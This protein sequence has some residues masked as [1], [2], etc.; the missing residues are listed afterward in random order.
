M[1][2]HG[3]WASLLGLTCIAVPLGASARDRDPARDAT[4]YLRDAYGAARDERDCRRVADD[5][6]RVL[7][8]L[9]DRPSRRDL[10]RAADDLERTRDDAQRDCPRSVARDIDDA[11][12]ALGDRGGRDRAPPIACWAPKDPGCEMERDGNRPLDATAF[13]ELTAALDR[14][15]NE[16][17][18]EDICKQSF[19]STYLTVA[20]LAHV[21]GKLRNELTMLEVV[22]AAASHVVNPK[23]A[24][25]LRARFRNSITASDA[26]AAVEGG[27]ARKPAPGTSESKGFNIKLDLGF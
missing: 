19:A 12:A 10:D 24:A 27:G 16:L 2:S 6:E 20:Q 26:V 25:E 1:R 9:R 3:I 7:D 18:R 22:K 11:I 17:T 8:E 14:E 21:L 13:A 15:M 5:L 23:A 4:R